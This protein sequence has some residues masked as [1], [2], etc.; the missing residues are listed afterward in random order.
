MTD[1]FIDHGD[2]DNNL[3]AADSLIANQLALSRAAV[4]E[5]AG[6]VPMLVEPDMKL[7]V[8][9]PAL[10]FD[11]NP[12]VRRSSR[13]RAVNS[14]LKD[15][16]VLFASTDER[17]ELSD[18]QFLFRV[19]QAFINAAQ[20][21]PI[22]LCQPLHQG[23]VSTGD[24]FDKSLTSFYALLTR[25][26]QNIPSVDVAVRDP[27]WKAAMQDEYDSLV[28]NGT[29]SLVS[30]EDLPANSN[31]VDCKW[32][33]TEKKSGD[34][35]VRPKARLVAKGFTQEF[36]VDYFETFAPVAK[37]PTFRIFLALSA[38]HNFSLRHL[39]VKNAFLQGDLDEEIYMRQPQH[40]CVSGSESFVCRLHRPIYGLKQSPRCWNQKLSAN[41]ES[42]G[43][44][45]HFQ[46]PDVCLYV[47]RDG[48]RVV[49]L[50]V[51]VDDIFVGDNCEQMGSSVVT[52]LMTS[53]KMRDLGFPSF[54]LGMHII[55]T[56][57]GLVLQ[58]HQYAQQILSFANMSSCVPS[59]T[60]MDSKL[61]L[62]RRQ[63]QESVCDQHL[64]RQIVG[65]LLY[66]C[67]SRPDLC[68]S[69]S[70][71]CKYVSDPSK[72]HWSALQRVLQYLKKTVNFGILYRNTG[73]VKLECFADSSWKSDPDDGK[74]VSGFVLSIN[75]SPV[76]FAS[77]K[78]ERVAKSTTEAEYYSLSSAVQD[79]LWCRQVQQFF[80][81]PCLEATNIFQ[82]NLRT[83]D[84]ANNPTSH[85]RMK[86]IPL[87][88]HFIR[89]EVHIGSVKLHPISTAEMVAD[90]FTKALSASKFQEFTRRLNVS[91]WLHQFDGRKN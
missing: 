90:I 24:M 12:P 45:V 2:V 73:S 36:G 5:P 66:L 42:Y 14:R 89:D 69:V 15:F 53:F 33:L 67:N 43:F 56:T 10:E 21:R 70:T 64:Y 59:G 7:A 3:P 19:S 84:F 88:H 9:A 62:A 77:R 29:W 50:L 27:L 85:T 32:V 65:A 44:D 78:Q 57:Q 46:R 86:H 61:K 54:F 30:A 13:T 6:P 17:S 51:Y 58:Q 83:I 35:S 82:D 49:A 25:D 47:K 60:P 80:G 48:D 71:L 31:I 38:L 87:E 39:D 74:S 23:L 20:S 37:M 4:V 72:A 76:V 40:F 26:Q 55:K 1:Q 75:Q 18:S 52:H 16:Y 91:D 11:S 41:L 81:W 34:G 63:P 28:E 68:F 22:S 8:P 79:V